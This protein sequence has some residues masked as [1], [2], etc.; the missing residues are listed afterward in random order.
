LARYLSCETKSEKQ[1]AL[2]D[3]QRHSSLRKTFRAITIT[4]SEHPDHPSNH[5][6]YL[7]GIIR[8]E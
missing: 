2:C 8:N 4:V 6:D 3:V 5:Y 7:I 1:L